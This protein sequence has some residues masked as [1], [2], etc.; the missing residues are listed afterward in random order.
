MSVITKIENDICTGFGAEAEHSWAILKSDGLAHTA[1]NGQIM[2]MLMVAAA[3][4]NPISI[5]LK[6]LPGRPAEIT[7][8]VVNFAPKP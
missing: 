3:H 1:A 8:I 5:T 7:G 4:Q 2:H 6:T